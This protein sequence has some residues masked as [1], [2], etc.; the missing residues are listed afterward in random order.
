MLILITLLARLVTTGRLVVD[1]RRVGVATVV[2]ITAVVGTI[3]LVTVLVVVVA[4][5]LA[6]VLRTGHAVGAEV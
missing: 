3:L 6:V 2:V 5:W 1:V 4:L